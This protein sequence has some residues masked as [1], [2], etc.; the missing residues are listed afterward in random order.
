MHIEFHGA[1]GTTTGSCFLVQVGETRFLVDCGMYQGPKAITARNEKPFPFLP[2]SIDFVLLTHAHIDHSGLLP[3]LVREGFNGPIYGTPATVDLLKLLLQ[4]AAHIQEKDAE[5]RNRKSR[6][7]G[8]IIEEPLYTVE[9]AEKA[10]QQSRTINYHEPYQCAPG[11]QV[12]FRDAGHILGSAFLEIDLSEG[13]KTRRVVFSGDVGDTDQAIIR[14]PETATEADVLILESTYG[15]RRHRDKADTLRELG[16]IL[17]RSHREG[18]NVVI[19]A[20]AVGRTQE[21]LYQLHR[22]WQEGRLPP[23]QVFVDSPMAISATDIYR[24]HPE[25]FDHETVQMLLNDEGPFTLPNL[26]FTRDV[27][28]SIRINFVPEPSIII[29]A[30]GMCHAGRILH[31]LKHNLWRRD[32]HVVF[33]GFQAEG[34]LGRALVDG[35]P[36]VKIMG[37]QI[38]VLAKIHTIGGLSAHADRD[39]LMEWA[40]HFK[41]SKPIVYVVHGEE[42]ASF[43]LAQ[44]LR[45]AY[46]FDTRLPAWHERFAL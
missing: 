10:C 2:R 15:D 24:D 41:Q 1:V 35:T 29:S 17:D 44:S 3:R 6:R 12:V 28:E 16:E 14:D 7:A 27:Q 33:V 31:H 26:H 40:G 8:H 30:S 13:D 22:L 39:G 43:A 42:Q 34:T 23:F 32:S 4:D 18:G 19:P 36:R 20:F 46:R 37:E 11:V 25:C 9:D 21:I 38:A 5:W 45:S